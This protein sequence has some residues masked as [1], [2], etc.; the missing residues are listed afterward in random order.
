MRAN[1]LEAGI[2][3][4]DKALPETIIIEEL[5]ELKNGADCIASGCSTF[6]HA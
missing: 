1:E 2:F 5:D 4:H 3:A 6:R